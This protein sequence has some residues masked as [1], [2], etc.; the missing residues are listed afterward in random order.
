MS[1]KARFRRGLLKCLYSRYFN[2]EFLKKSADWYF[3]QTYLFFIA[4]YGNA[5]FLRTDLTDL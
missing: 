1:P 4:V 2:S 3:G 5:R